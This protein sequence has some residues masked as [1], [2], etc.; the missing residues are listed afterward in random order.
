M[1]VSQTSVWHNRGN[2]LELARLY[3]QPTPIWYWCIR[4]IF[5]VRFILL[6]E[7]LRTILPLQMIGPSLLVLR[8]GCRRQNAQYLLFLRVHPLN[9]CSCQCCPTAPQVC[10]S[11]RHW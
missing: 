2:T 11:F 1:W 8:S 7:R 5:F 4:V 10:F 9:R 3:G 6:C